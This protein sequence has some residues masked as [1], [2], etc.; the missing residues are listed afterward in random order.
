MILT[1]MIV[2]LDF[3]VLRARQ[4]EVSV[5]NHRID[6]TLM[7]VKGLDWQHILKVPNLTNIFIN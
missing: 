6:A 1:T 4:Q 2:Y 5:Q 7:P 3:I